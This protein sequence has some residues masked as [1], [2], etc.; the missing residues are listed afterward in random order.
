MF[1]EVI[2]NL[3]NR[4]A[5]TQSQIILVGV[6][7][8]PDSVCLMQLL[9]EN[10]FP[11]IVGYFHHNLRPEADLEAISVENTCKSLDVPFCF[12]TGETEA[13]ALQNSLTVEESARILRYKFLFS[14]AKIHKA[15]AVAVAHTADDQVE[16]LLMHLLR[17]SGLSGLTG[18]QFR[19]LPN[20]WSSEISLIR[21]LLAVWKADIRK[22]LQ[23][24]GLDA[25]LD[26]SNL[27]ARYTRNRIRQELLPY[28]ETFNPQ[29]KKVLWQTADL[30]DADYLELDENC[31]F[32][33]QTCQIE[34]GDGYLCLDRRRIEQ[35]TIGLQRRILRRGIE[36]L[37]PGLI[38]V[39][40]STIQR[41]L[42][43]IQG[44]H[45]RH[46]DLSS[47]LG[48][49]VEDELVWI[50]AQSARLPTQQW[51]QIHKNV[52]INLA[53]P[54]RTALAGM[55]EVMIS[56]V[57]KTPDLIKQ[58]QIKTDRDQA[59]L[60][61][62][63][64]TQSLFMRVRVAGDRFQPYGMEG[65]SVKVSDFLINHKL[66]LRARDNWPLV[67][68][69]D[70]IIWIPGFQIAHN[71]RVRPETKQLLHLHLKLIK[72]SEST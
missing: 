51:P 13:Y 26:E 9:H 48:L 43:C 1:E 50:Y 11:I 3:R 18:M 64:I 41:G 42:A 19:S 32:V 47:G 17:G 38:D 28:L 68:H 7:G 27:D 57:E 49:K 46:C 2:D 20:S 23:Q 37:Q 14:Q 70:E 33:F 63:S 56:V 34:V 62:E 29:I 53:I 45:G 72:D 40:Y 22:F 15:Q 12:G 52:T 39:D 6:S 61:K 71:F 5:I 36:L 4:C 67:C 65:K 8:G 21:P 35:L 16:T 54:G 24:K 58:I 10:K 55:W 44:F 30:L 66:P 59:W 31:Q 60:A 25:F 69:G